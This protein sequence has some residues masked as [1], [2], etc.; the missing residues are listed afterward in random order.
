MALASHSFFLDPAID[1][2]RQLGLLDDVLAL[3]VRRDA[4][5]AG[6]LVELRLDFRRVA[7]DR[8]R[9]TEDFGEVDGDDGDARLPEGS[10]R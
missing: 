9:G 5:V 8:L 4:S 7:V 2:E 1:G 3:D 10:F 6:D